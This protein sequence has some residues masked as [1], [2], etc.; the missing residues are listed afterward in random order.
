[1]KRPLR[2]PRTTGTPT[3]KKRR[4]PR[5]GRR[6]R[7]LIVT[8]SVLLVLFAGAAIAVSA[9]DKKILA[10]IDEIRNARPLP[11]LARPLTLRTGQTIPLF[12]VWHYLVLSRE[13]GTLPF[14]PIFDRT[15][16]TIRIPSG[17][18]RQTSIGWSET[19]QIAFI[20]ASSRDLPETSLEQVTLPPLHLG[21]ILEGRTLEY[22]PVAFSEISP[23]LKETFLLSED[24]RFF[25]SP[26]LDLKGIGRAFF[27]DIKAHRFKEGGS[28]LT[29]Q[30]VKILFLQRRKTLT[31]KFEEAILALRMAAILP[32]EKIFSL[33]LNHIDL[34]GYGTERIIGVEAAS[35]LYFGRHANQD[36]WKEAA[37]LAALAR[38]PTYYSPFL[39]PKRT[40]SLRN[41][42]L[43]LLYRHKVL[44]EKEWRTLSSAPLGLIEPRG[45]FHP[46]GPYF[47]SEVARTVAATPP[48]GALDTLRTTMDPLIQ[49]EAD[50]LLSLFLSRYDRTL[51]P[52]IRTLHPHDLQGVL[53]VM[54]PRTGEVRAMT[55]GRDFATSPLNRA[56][57]SKRQPA[58]LFKIVPYLAALSPT[59]DHPAPFTLASALS[60]AP[61]NRLLGHKKWRPK[62]DIY[63]P[64]TTILLF[65]A[66]ARSM[67]LPAIHMTEALSK[68]D[69]VRTAHDLGLDT[70]GPSRIPLS[71]PLG[72]ITQT[73]L[74]M[75]TAYSRIANGGL[76]VSPVLLARN[77]GDSALPPPKRIFPEAP[78]YLLWSAL[79]RVLDDGTGTSFLLKDPERDH[80]AGKTGT[81]N[82]GRDAWFVALSPRE[83]VL[84]WVGFDDNTPT[85]R[86]GAQL[87]LPIV[88]SLVVWQNMTVPPLPPPGDIVLADIDRKTG[89]LANPVCGPSLQ[90]PFIRGTVPNVGCTTTLPP[91]KE[92]PIV[93]FFRQFF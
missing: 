58:S 24:R 32:P 40:V 62:N 60:N 45:L 25:S 28:T 20:R 65:R 85:M 78:A 51:P 11:V 37:T 38:A 86:F 15:A 91:S 55:G 42:I 69:L 18:G 8:L 89:L 53:I 64:R 76:S 70:P 35:L 16:R 59:P 31:R 74:Q 67:N 61:M 73:P 84:C 44:A 63:D 87:A 7:I 80:W 77:P 33:Y 3:A 36:G 43:G 5:P 30:V 92:N 21:S 48:S 19:G 14:S 29:Q 54:D 52:K 82:R 57:R 9:I 81:A 17:P 39:H 71:Y 22:R 4:A 75:A 72:V 6:G 90:L 41:H 47:L 26:A 1:M 27:H 46:L 2:S 68:D 34:G 10:R 66:L 83:V 56:T 79:Q 49:E 50:H 88:S 93:H 13:G 23:S 12:G